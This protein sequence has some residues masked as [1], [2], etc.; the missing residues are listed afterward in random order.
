MKHS[1]VQEIEDLQ[2]ECDDLRVIIEVLDCY[3]LNKHKPR[4]KRDIEEKRK[5][6]KR[7][8]E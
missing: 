8:K 1:L 3:V 2:N 5:E 7:C 6:L 4:I